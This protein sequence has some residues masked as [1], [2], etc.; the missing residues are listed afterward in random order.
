MATGHRGGAFVFFQKGFIR[1]EKVAIHAELAVPSL[2]VTTWPCGGSR[3]L[4]GLLE[5]PVHWSRRPAVLT[6][7]I[8]ILG[9][10]LL[11]LH[12]HTPLCTPALHGL[13][14]EVWVHSALYCV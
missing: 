10:L 14:L 9:W 12:L 7:W 5:L 11:L 13:L 3:R 2:E 4:R 8:A 1:V 6:V